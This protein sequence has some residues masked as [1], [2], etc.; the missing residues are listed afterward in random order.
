MIDVFIKTSDVSLHDNGVPA[1]KAFVVPGRLKVGAPRRIAAKYARS[2]GSKSVGMRSIIALRL[3]LLGYRDAKRVE[4]EIP[5]W[6]YLCCYSEASW[7]GWHKQPF[8]KYLQRIDKLH[9]VFA[10]LR[11]KRLKGI[12]SNAR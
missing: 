12:K 7:P 11:F 10:A 6:M 8:G 1:F 4:I 3:M 2:S 9:R 5:E